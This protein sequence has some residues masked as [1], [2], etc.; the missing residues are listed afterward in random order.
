MIIFIFY[1]N[2][3][4]GL[5][6]RTTTHLRFHLHVLVSDVIHHTPCPPTPFPFPFL[7][8]ISIST[9]YIPSSLPLAFQRTLSM[10]T[11]GQCR[12]DVP[13]RV[14]FMVSFP[15]TFF[16]LFLLFLYLS[17]SPF[18]LLLTILCTLFS[19]LARSHCPCVLLVY[20]SRPRRRLVTFSCILHLCS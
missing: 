18:S 7:C 5:S 15:F 19:N 11:S 8:Q 13:T 9:I 2:I 1:Y 6:L 20:F 14:A 4:S 12:N 16:Y 17:T 3:D 10:A